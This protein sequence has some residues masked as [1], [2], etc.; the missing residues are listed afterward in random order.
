M[1]W[2]AVEI[3]PFVV[4]YRYIVLII[5]A[6]SAY[7]ALKAVIKEKEAEKYMT[8]VFF[9][10][11]A[12]TLLIWKFSYILFHPVEAINAPVRILYF[13]GGTLGWIIG[14]VTGLL[15]LIYKGRKADFPLPQ[16]ILALSAIIMSFLA[17]YNGIIWGLNGFV[18]VIFLIKSLSSLAF[19]IALFMHINMVN[20]ISIWYFVVQAA[21]VFAEER[22]TVFLSFSVGQLLFI[23]AA[24]GLLLFE[25]KY[26][27]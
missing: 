6:I 1:I 4:Q 5:S 26:R 17:V 22:S 21:I 23:A 8:D 20:Y 2:N 13:S 27:S 25:W 9:N 16:W 14:V 3:G 15:Y 7:I 24:V 19:L 18:D 10:T 12:F 11:A